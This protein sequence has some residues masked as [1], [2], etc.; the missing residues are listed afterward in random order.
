MELLALGALPGV[1]MLVVSEAGG[2][3]ELGAAMRVPGQQIEAERSQD[4]EEPRIP[5]PAGS[6]S[7]RRSSSTPPAA[8]GSVISVKRISS[9][10]SMMARFTVCRTPR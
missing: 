10:S 6:R 3:V 1:E 5:Q 2:A 9:G 8:F 7:R 4:K